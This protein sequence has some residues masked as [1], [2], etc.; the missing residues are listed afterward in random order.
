MD[1][2][3]RPALARELELLASVHFLIKRE[4][5]PDRTPKTITEALHRFDKDFDERDVERAIVGMKN[6]GLVS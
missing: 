5:V 3:D 4:Q 6:N 2:S 1:T